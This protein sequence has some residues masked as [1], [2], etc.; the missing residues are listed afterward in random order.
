MVTAEKCLFPLNLYNS[1][2]T[3][4][5]NME[6]CLCRGGYSKVIYPR[7]TFVAPPS[8]PVTSPLLLPVTYTHPCRQRDVSQVTADEKTHAQEG[9]RSPP[10]SPHSRGRRPRPRWVFDTTLGVSKKEAAAH[11]VLQEVCYT[12]VGIADEVRR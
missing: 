4:T 1:C 9:R 5:R 10:R 12:C 7:K 11:D 8:T 3:V 2:S 6:A